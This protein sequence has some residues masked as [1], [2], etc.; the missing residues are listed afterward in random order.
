MIGGFTSDPDVGSPSWLLQTRGDHRSA[1]RAPAASVHIGSLGRRSQGRTERWR[2]GSSADLTVL[3]R[4]GVEGTPTS[5]V[6]SRSLPSVSAAVSTQFLR[7]SM[8]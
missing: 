8:S 5:L 4:G 3:P 6:G 1:R 7:S 2:D